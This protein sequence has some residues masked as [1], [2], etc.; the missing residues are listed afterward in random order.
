MN[1]NVPAYEKQPG[2]GADKRITLNSF[3]GGVYQDKTT[4]TYTRID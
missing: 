3:G 2:T 4:G 1:T